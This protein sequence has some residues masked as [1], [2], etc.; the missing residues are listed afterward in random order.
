MKKGVIFDLDGTLIDTPAGIVEGF[1]Y[2][3]N[4]LNYFNINAI[5]IRNTIGLPLEKAFASLLKVDTSDALISAAIKNYHKAFNEIVLPKAKQL[6][7]S[8]VTK[9]LTDLKE[10]G[11]TLAIATSKYLKSANNLLT[12]A[13]LINYFDLIVGA[14][15]VNNPKPHPEMGFLV[16]E[17]LQLSPKNTFMIGDTTHDLFMANEAGIRSIGVTY[18]IHDYKKLESANPEY[19]SDN[20]SNVVQYILQHN[21]WK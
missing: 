4:C 11:Y 18:G 3:L 5:D 20:F 16:I 9:G 21:H 8:G 2:S 14:D 19:I 17:K 7:F 13:E 6:I 10:Q 12:A 1:L 15:L